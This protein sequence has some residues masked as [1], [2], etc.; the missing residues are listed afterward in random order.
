MKIAVA[1]E[2]ASVC[3]ARGMKL[4]LGVPLWLVCG[5][6]GAV[7]ATMKGRGGCFWFLLCAVL[8]PFGLVLAAIISRNTDRG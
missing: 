2:P 3:Y 1:A 6:V 5:I 4:E 8:G 7:I